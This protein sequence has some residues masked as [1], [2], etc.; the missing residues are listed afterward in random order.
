MLQVSCCTFVLLNKVDYPGPQ[1][2]YIHEKSRGEFI[3]Q[4]VQMSL[5]VCNFCCVPGILPLH[6]RRG[7]PLPPGPFRGLFTK[8]TLVF[9]CFAVYATYEQVSFSQVCRGEVPGNSHSAHEMSHRKSKNRKGGRQPG[10]RQPP[11][12]R[13]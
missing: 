4:R 2:H 6:K 9:P 8:A 3:L 10:V 12:Y 11:P 13:R 1:K 7:I 5:S